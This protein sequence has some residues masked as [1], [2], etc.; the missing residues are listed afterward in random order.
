MSVKAIINPEMLRWA[1][2]T[3]GYSIDEASSKIFGIRMRSRIQKLTMCERG[4]VFLTFKQLEKVANLYKRPLEAFYLEEVPALDI[5]LPDFRGIIRDEYVKFPQLQYQIRRVREFRENLLELE[6]SHDFDWIYVG[7]I[8]KNSDYEATS[9]I[10]R[11]KL[12]IEMEQQRS[13][14][15]TREALKNWIELIERIGILV[16]KVPKIP[17]EVMRGFSIVEKKYP[18]I[19]INSQ[20]TESGKI[21]TLLHELAHVFIGKSGLCN[22]FDAFG[23]KFDPLEIFCNYLAGAILIP[24]KF[25]L[26]HTL[27]KTHT[28]LTNWDDNDIKLVAKDFK[29]SMDATLRRILIHNKVTKKH[30]IEKHSKYRAFIISEK[31]RKKKKRKKK[32]GG[33]LPE[34]TFKS[35]MSHNYLFFIFNALDKKKITE[36]D[37]LRLLNT[38]EK[39]F[40]RVI[41]SIF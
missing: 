36:Y 6:I 9:E 19:V 26:N 34:V 17:T 28:D 37:A 22:P 20:D 12:G 27:V 31:E 39:V 4:E 3:I 33:P 15:S 2:N 30:Y 7:S 14:K 13:W 1:R 10:I 38:T 35:Q 21:F 5:S 16:F 23:A 24:K 40:K 11:K 29:S 18:V 8:T 32:S 41:G 25:L